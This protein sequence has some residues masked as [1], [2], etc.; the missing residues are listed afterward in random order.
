MAAL[1]E[2]H[3][4]RDGLGHADR[5]RLHYAF[6]LDAQSR[7]VRLPVAEWRHSNSYAHS[8]GNSYRNA[9]ANSDCHCHGNSNTQA[10]AD[11]KACSY[12]EAA[13]NTASPR[14]AGN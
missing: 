13:T 4:A 6:G 12:A 11:S 14:I 2:R 7:G 1:R 8:N 5:P 9:D 10:D 3:S